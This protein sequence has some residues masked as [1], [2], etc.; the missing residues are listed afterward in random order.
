MVPCQMPL[1]IIVLN[2]LSLITGI[3]KM[4]SQKLLK[5]FSFILMDYLMSLLLLS[6][7]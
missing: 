5:L 1:V 2:F 4:A 3:L 6:P 7:Y